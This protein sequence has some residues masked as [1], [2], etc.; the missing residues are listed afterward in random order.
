M[1]T[2]CEKIYLNF[3]KGIVLGK[4]SGKYL[5]VTEKTSL[6]GNNGCTNREN[7]F[8]DITCSLK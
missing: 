4:N 8:E 7:L 5:K 6:V 3:K 1:F 2:H